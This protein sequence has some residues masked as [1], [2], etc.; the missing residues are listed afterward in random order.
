MSDKSDWLSWA[1]AEGAVPM[2]QMKV[3]CRAVDRVLCWMLGKLNA[4]PHV[5]AEAVGCLPTDACPT[6]RPA[7][8]KPVERLA[9]A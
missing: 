5:Q 2:H 9:A 6:G 4:A 1:R 8:L 3:L 7:S